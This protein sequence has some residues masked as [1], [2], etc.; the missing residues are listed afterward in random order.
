M[1]PSKGA[2]TPLLFMGYLCLSGCCVAWKG[3]LRKAKWRWM[4]KQF[5]T[6]VRNKQTSLEV[7]LPQRRS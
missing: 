4:K 3:E 7:S 5:A 1:G 2:A 6:N